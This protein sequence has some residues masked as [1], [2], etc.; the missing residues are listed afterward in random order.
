MKFWALCKLLRLSLKRDFSRAYS[1]VFGI[2][3]AVG[4]LLFFLGV[5]LGLITF[6]QRLFPVD[7]KRFEVRAPKWAVG[8]TEQKALDEA[9]CA[10]FQKLEHVHALY[11]KMEVHAPGATRIDKVLNL[12]VNMGLEVVAVGVEPSLFEAE[13]PRELFVEDKEA[14]PVVLNTHLLEVYNQHFAP[15][16]GLPLLRGEMLQGFGFDVFF[17]QSFFARSAGEVVAQEFFVAGFSP[18]AFLAGISIPLES[19]RRLNR[20]LGKDAQHYSSVVVEAKDSAHV[21]KLMQQLEQMGFKVEE[22]ERSW[23]QKLGLAVW[24]TTGGLSLLSL[25]IGILATLNI[26]QAFLH[27]LRMRENEFAIFRAVGATSAQLMW[28]LVTE[29]LLLALL[30]GGLGIVA[31]LGG[32]HMLNVFLFRTLGS[33]PLL[34]PRFFMLP[35]EGCLLGLTGAILA[36]LL[37]VWVPLRRLRKMEPAVVLAGR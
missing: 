5:G 2:S 24:A 4:S 7:A 30:G 19:A 25:L 22:G 1:S 8:E 31:A 37:G 34:P 36:A 32:G 33:L 17:N 26:T 14:V 20:A 35:V 21:P 28:T 23:A 16:N 15:K 29:A 27:S 6:I 11:R 12:R 13:V 3:L 18:K 9:A 10:E